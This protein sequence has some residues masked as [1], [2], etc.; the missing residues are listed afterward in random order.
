[1]IRV[2]QMNTIKDLYE[3]DGL[4]LR[5]IARRTDL[6][7]Q[8]VQKYA[9]KEDWSNDN[10][11]NIEPSSYPVLEPYIPTIDAWLDADR[12]IPR[13]QRHT[14]KRIYDRLRD[15]CGFPGSYSSVKKYVR[16]KKFVMKAATEGYLPLAHP[17]GCG[18]VDFGEFIYY[19]GKQEEHNAYALT[20]SFPNSN[21]G[22]TQAF[23]S[24]NQECLLTGMQRIFE[25]IGGVPPR[26]RFD[27]MTTAVAQ[28]LEG[29]ERVLADG[30]MRFK[31]HYRFQADFCNPRSGNEKGN[32]ENKVGYSRRN[33][34]VPVP[35]ITSFE[36]F[37]ESLWDW[38][39][40]DAERPHYKYKVSIQEL[41]REEQD[42][43]LAL[44][45]YPF[46]VFR[47]E[48]MAVNKYGFAVIDT[49]KYGLA[50]SLYGE[51]VQAKIFYDHV[52]FF[53]DHQLVGK[54]RRSY[55]SNEEIYDWTQYVSTL[56]K[57]PGAI[58]HTRFFHQMPQPWQQHL[59]QSRGKDRKNALQLLQEIVR[60]GNAA[61]CND[62][63]ELAG[64]NGRTDADSMRQ[65]YYMIA[66]KEYRPEPLKMI[67]DAPALNYNPN[68]S[69]YDGLMVGGEA[70]G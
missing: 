70:H 21:K 32:V 53:H 9:Y 64:V 17:D 46:P 4:S 54:Y 43:L 60:D 39:E 45:E 57:K 25:H 31:L 13:K 18:Q 36:E 22:Y 61:L 11:P 47:Y 20:I 12:K 24:Q 59:E 48:S 38:C 52:E 28:V 10:L 66:K 44:P 56:C 1:V 16:K 68:L 40:K 27:N 29:T 35:T 58:E 69:A 5:E 7:F 67:S 30:F 19:D 34:F 33:A 23:P 3:N 50:P 14:V 62:V 63:L 2:T 41:W 15:E 8:T 26:L 42:S 6:S 37:N 65:C 55:G 51:T 49:N